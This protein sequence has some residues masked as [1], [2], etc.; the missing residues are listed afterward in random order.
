MVRKTLMAA[1]D[2]VRD[3]WSRGPV[4]VSPSPCSTGTRAAV[5][6]LGTSTSI[7]RIGAW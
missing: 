7:D 2:V 4:V 3:A 1:A 5:C 6:Q